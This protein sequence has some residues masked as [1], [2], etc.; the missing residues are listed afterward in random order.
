MKGFYDSFCW[1]NVDIKVVNDLFTREFFHDED[2]E[3]ADKTV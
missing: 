3:H 2:L 1:Q